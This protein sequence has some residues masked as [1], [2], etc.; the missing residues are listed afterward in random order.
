MLYWI[1]FVADTW[2]TTVL[3]KFPDFSLLSLPMQPVVGLPGLCWAALCLLG[4]L[5]S[6]EITSSCQISFLPKEQAVGTSISLY[7][8]AWSCC[9]LLAGFVSFWKPP[10]PT[11]DTTTDLVLWQALRQGETMQRCGLRQS[12]PSR[13]RSCF[14]D[15]EVDTGTHLHVPDRAWLSRSAV[16][17]PRPGELEL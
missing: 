6:W 17:F 9:W 16:A 3:S 13:E 7:M 1:V 4:Q 8:A 14:S 5:D 11:L 15:E 12:S 2:N 10:L